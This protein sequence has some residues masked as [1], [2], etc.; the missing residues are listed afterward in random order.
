MIQKSTK[1]F[2]KQLFVTLIILMVINIGYLFRYL[3]TGYIRLL[4]Y[5]MGP[6]A[7]GVVTWLM[8]YTW[9]KK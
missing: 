7:T 5:V 2:I 6:W 3:G 8:V 1:L 9:V 4:G